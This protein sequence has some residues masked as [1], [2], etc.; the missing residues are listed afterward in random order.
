MIQIRCERCSQLLSITEEMTG[1]DKK[2]PKVSNWFCSDNCRSIHLFENYPNEYEKWHDPSERGF[3]LAPTA[4]TQTPPLWWNTDKEPFVWGE[5]CPIDLTIDQRKKLADR[6]SLNDLFLIDVDK[7]MLD[8]Y[9]AD[10]KAA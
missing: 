4:A 9:I 10:I 3:L 1:P 2:K 5:W 8:E 7:E 6:L